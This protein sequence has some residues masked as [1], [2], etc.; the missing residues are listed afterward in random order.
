MRLLS[1]PHAL[2]L[3][4]VPLATGCWMISDDEQRA[5]I[6]GDGDGVS[7]YDD[8]DDA[9]PRVGEPAALFC[10]RDGDGLGSEPV[11]ACPNAT[12]AE[13]AA[14]CG[15]DG[16]ALVTNSLDCDDDDPSVLGSEPQPH[17]PDNDGDGLGDSTADPTL[18]CA[19]PEGFV[20]NND[21]CDDT[22]DDPT[23]SNP[24][25]RYPDQDGDGFGG[26]VAE[27]VCPG[28][29]DHVDNDDDCN[30]TDPDITT[31]TVVYT[32]NDNDGFGVGDPLPAQCPAPGFVQIAGDC[33]DTNPNIN[34][35]A[36]QDPCSLVDQDCDAATPFGPVNLNQA[37][38]HP[39]INDA[40]DAATGGG[41]IEVCPGHH[42]PFT[43]SEDV[44]IVGLG[45]TRDE[46]IVTASSVAARATTATVTAGV[47][48]TLR[49]L[50]LADGGGTPVASDHLGGNLYLLGG[51]QV[52]L[53]NVRVT[54]G[55]ATTG[56][57]IY[58]SELAELTLHDVEIDANH[59]DLGGGGIYARGS[60]LQLTGATIIHV[61]EATSGGS[62]SA[63]GGGLYLL[64]STA[65]AESTVIVESNASD[66]GGGM[67]VDEGA[68][69]GGILRS[70]TSTVTGGNAFL[71]GS[72]LSDSNVLN[73]NT[74]VL[75]GGVYMISLPNGE[76]A[77]GA[78]RLT[79]VNIEGNVAATGG[80][81]VASSGRNIVEACTLHDNQALGG[82]AGTGD[83]GGLYH[84]TGVITLTDT[85]I[86][87]NVA[88]GLGGGAFID[89]RVNANDI[90]VA[91]NQADIGGGIYIDVT[92]LGGSITTST[93]TGNDATL[94]GGAMHVTANNATSTVTLTDVALDANSANNGG[95]ISISNARAA[96][97]NSSAL[98]NT[99]R[100]NGG[101]FY[102]TA[103]AHLTLDSGSEARTNTAQVRGPFAYVV[104]GDSRVFTTN[105]TVV[106]HSTPI[107][108][109][110]A[111]HL[112]LGRLTS[113]GTTWSNNDPFDVW[114][115]QATPVLSSN[116]NTIGTGSVTCVSATLGGC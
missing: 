81:G 114:L 23:A 10:D 86:T 3:L 38:A 2:P 72:S 85:T 73:G 67:L 92:L 82:G 6:D 51:A 107:T 105:A 19:N 61:N 109:T 44:T 45:A 60:T 84:A 25:L 91:D 28:G 95:A 115:D 79:N 27:L 26:P 76:G 98:S 15:A 74:G 99:A 94:T 4:C 49:N 102:L 75:G 37:S 68:W 71:S 106:G 33:D 24:V 17:W 30:D 80:G 20:D 5:R 14:L 39:T 11:T 41:V 113:S 34:P 9:D 52:T 96:L 18:H 42:A 35:D 87:D 29:T 66:S 101:G 88:G 62:A 57:G 55:L 53:E 40:V 64:G 43:V 93:F 108:T 56:G 36:T 89:G 22:D 90:V 112:Q 65:H 58:T 63:G 8:C 13:I 54:K 104:D 110:G 103:G 100:N 111:L 69:S 97:G 32:D 12:A 77:D 21:D 50:T 31:P 70:N 78:S 46:V 116:G 7:V 1:L 48:L 83:G 16:A 59:A 47:T